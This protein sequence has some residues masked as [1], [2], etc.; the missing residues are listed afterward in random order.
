MPAARVADIPPLSSREDYFDWFDGMSTDLPVEHRDRET[1]GG[2]QKSYLLENVGSSPGTD[3][4]IHLLGRSGLTAEPVGD[5]TEL[6]RIISENGSGTAL[7]ERLDHRFFALYTLLRSEASD[8]LVNRAVNRN[9]AL[10]HIWLSTDSFKALWA[11]VRATNSGR[12]YGRITFEHESLFDSEGDG[13]G[14]DEGRTSR[15]TMIDR[16]QVIDQSMS[17]LQATYAPLGSITHLRIPALGGGGHDLY[18]DGK[19]TNRSHSFLGHRSAL[20]HVTDMYSQLTKDLERL[21]W[22]TAREENSKLTLDG[23]V[24][25]FMFSAPLLE[26]TFRRWVTSLFSTSRN[27]FHVTGFPTWLGT[28]KVQA[29]AIDQN[30]WQPF[31]LEITPERLVAVLPEGTCGNLINRLLSSV[32]RHVDPNVR[33]Y[34]AGRDYSSLIPKDGTRTVA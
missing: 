31:L 34:V 30:L 3:G 23:S 12:R 25:E 27:R 13:N 6:F 33:A 2:L 14:D 26:S 4:F 8:S 24:A 19:V 32:Q 21:L 28:R 22:V 7:V 20:L 1:P 15:F 9:P 29:S 11:H 16:L 18:F 5:S 10:D 17:P